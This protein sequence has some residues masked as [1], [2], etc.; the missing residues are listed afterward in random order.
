MSLY[1]LFVDPAACVYLHER[2]KS[3]SRMCVLL[4]VF[5]FLATVYACESVCIY[6]A[7]RTYHALLA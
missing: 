4:L 1:A 6:H 5:Q 3:E 2:K 7:D